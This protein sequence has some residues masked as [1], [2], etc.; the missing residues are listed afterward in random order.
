MLFIQ[1]VGGLIQKQYFWLL[2]KQL[3]Q[4][5]FCALPAAQLF[6]NF[7]HTD[8]C[9]AKPRRHTVNMA[10]NGIEI[11]VLQGFLQIGRLVDQ[12]FT[13]ILHHFFVQAV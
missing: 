11:P 6:K 7:I 9:N 8:G 3:C 13:G 4:D 5:D 2:E 1:K 12:L 10:F